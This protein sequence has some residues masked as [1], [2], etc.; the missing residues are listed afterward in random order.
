MAGKPP[1][2]E[3]AM[4]NSIV[5]SEDTD[6]SADQTAPPP[7]IQYV[8]PIK[9]DTSLY[10][11]IAEIYRTYDNE[12]LE[13][14][15]DGGDVMAIK[16]MAHRLI[17]NPSSLNATDEREMEEELKLW[18]EYKRKREKY[19]ELSLIYGSTDFSSDSA[20]LD[21]KH[22]IPGRST[23]TEIRNALLEKLAV[24][25]F[26]AMRGLQGQKLLIVPHTINSF[27]N[28]LDEP[29][30]LTEQDKAYI[31]DR[32]QAIYDHYEARRA[33]LG[34]GPFVDIEE[35]NSSFLDGI[36]DPIQEYLDAMGDN[37]F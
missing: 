37:A 20:T 29:V 32:A 22:W 13:A 28:Y 11:D 1:V 31:R 23:Q 35:Y 26:I 7:G 3:E 34:L 19:I 8:G 27:E 10:G 17:M 33:E 14:L 30:R 9:P 12:T 21:Y 4:F 25:E 16:V 15:A 2:T 6:D 18:E 5:A 36:Y 24:I